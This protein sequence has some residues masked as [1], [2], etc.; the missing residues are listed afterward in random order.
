MSLSVCGKDDVDGDN[1]AVPDTLKKG[2]LMLEPI[3]MSGAGLGEIY[4]LVVSL[5]NDPIHLQT[6]P[7]AECKMIT[8][9]ILVREIEVGRPRH[10]GV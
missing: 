6:E 9:Q 5:E 8:N 10:V 2:D 1:D 7:E 3:A 4:S